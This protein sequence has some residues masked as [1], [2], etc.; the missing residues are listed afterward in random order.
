MS[1]PEIQATGRWA[2]YPGLGS[3]AQAWLT[4]KILEL[5]AQAEADYEQSWITGYWQ[6]G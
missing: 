1:N 5:G 6:L 2:R 3:Q 4:T